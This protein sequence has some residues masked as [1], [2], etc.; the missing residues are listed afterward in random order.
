[1][2]FAAALSEH[3]VAAE[4]VGEVL[5]TILERGGVEPDLVVVFASSAHVEFLGEIS[6]AIRALLRPRTLVGASASAV[7]GGSREVEE[8]PALSVFA[9]WADSVPEPMHGVRLTV[10]ADD[11]AVD[12]LPDAMPDGATLLVLADAHTFPG[13]VFVDHLAAERPDVA[14]V[15]GLTS[16]QGGAASALVLD[17][18]VHRDGAVGVVIPRDLLVGPVVS[19]GCRPIGD[20]MAVTAVDRHFVLELAGRPALERLV[21]LTKSLP[22]E[23]QALVAGGLQLGIVI[24]ETKEDLDHG[25]FLVRSILGGDRARGV[26]AIGT[27]LPVGATVQFHV[28]DA[29]AAHVDLQALL[30]DVQGDGALLFTCNG[31]GR[32]LFGTDDHDAATVVD[33]VGTDAVAG[34]FCAGEVG[35]VGGRSF[36]HAFT[37]SVLVFTDA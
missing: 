3:P 31:R 36:L 8:V 21:E 32:A 10:G 18:V 4:A 33:L 22:P 30:S 26:L 12:G 17:G 37:A 24:D 34:M 6:T 19:Q 29:A 28:R 27:E 2:P 5:G 7:V 20:V 15:G 35:P 1:M 14:I 11:Q 25:D 9:A 13:E 23:E 16:A